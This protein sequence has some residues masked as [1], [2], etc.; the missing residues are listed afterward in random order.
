MGGR[1]A[2]GKLGRPAVRQAGGRAS[3]LPLIT[4]HPLPLPLP[5]PLPPRPEDIH[6]Y[7]LTPH[8]LYAAVSVGLDTP[9][10]ISVLDR[11]SK[12]HLS[13][14]LVAFIKESTQN[15]GKVTRRLGCWATRAPCLS[16]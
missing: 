14:D 2:A 13:P 7:S 10:I 4:F 1:Y 3:P 5:L 15:Y 8:S 11:L 16:S 6:E 12:T 9:T